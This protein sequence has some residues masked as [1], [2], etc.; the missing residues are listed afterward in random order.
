M[1]EKRGLFLPSDHVGSFV[2]VG[3][4]VKEALNAGEALSQVRFGVLAIVQILC[5]AATNIY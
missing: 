3:D 4:A 5:H 1:S 2:N